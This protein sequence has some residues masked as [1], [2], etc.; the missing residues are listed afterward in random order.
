MKKNLRSYPTRSG[1]SI[2]LRGL[3]SDERVF[4]YEVLRRFDAEPEW[5]E[6]A[7]W[8]TERFR[9]LGAPEGSPVH[10][11]CQD[12]EARLGIAQGKV[13]LPDYRDHLTDLIEERYGS[14]DVF[15]EKTGTDP[16]DLRRALANPSELSIRS[17]ERILEPLQA[18]LL[19][20]PAPDPK[21]WAISEQGRIAKEVLQIKEGVRTRQLWVP[22]LF[23]KLPEDFTPSPWCAVKAAYDERWYS[24]RGID[25]QRTEEGPRWIQPATAVD[26]TEGFSPDLDFVRCIVLGWADGTQPDELARAVKLWREER[27]PLIRELQQIV[28]MRVLDLKLLMFLVDDLPRLEK[29]FDALLES[30]PDSPPATAKLLAAFGPIPEGLRR[31][32]ELERTTP[33]RAI[34][35]N[36]EL[37]VLDRLAYRGY[38]LEEILKSAEAS[39]DESGW[40]T[41][42]GKLKRARKGRHGP[43]PRFLS[44]VIHGLYSYIRPIY[45][46]TFGDDRRNPQPLREHIRDLLS[47]YFAPREISPARQG[48]IGRAINTFIKKS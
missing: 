33:L 36:Q 21:E 42:D 22:R 28:N 8:W 9:R 3:S 48:T 16:R 20:Q 10:R 37:I 14:S 27:E 6:F 45:R 39:L 12:L 38:R 32:K 31:V 2:D 7:S 41:E 30:W 11:I 15:C 13:P 47:P 26:D 23:R 40:T 19:I 46:K 35:T 44:T 25:F 18:S 34:A 4:F 17:L 43:R 29:L 1:G 5:S 24:E